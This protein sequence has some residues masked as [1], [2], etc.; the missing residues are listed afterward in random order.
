MVDEK[1]GGAA[2][3]TWKLLYPKHDQVFIERITQNILGTL[4]CIKQEIKTDQN[5]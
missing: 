2:M 4:P 1:K 5:I 3:N